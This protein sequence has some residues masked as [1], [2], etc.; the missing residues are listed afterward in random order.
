MV[1]ML[2]RKNVL[3]AK[4][5]TT[6]GV[7]PTPAAGDDA[8][9]ALNTEIKETREPIERN[10]NISTLSNKPSLLGGEFAEVTFSV[11]IKGS[12]SAGTAPRLGALLQA[13]SMSETV[14]SSTSVTY[15]PESSDQNSVTLW[16]YID[17]RLHKINGAVGTVKLNL[18]AGA[19]G[20][21]DFT[22]QGKYTTPTS[23]AI[24]SGT[25][26]TPNPQPCK[27]CT[28]TYDSKTTLIAKMLDVDLANTIAR[29]N[30]LS[31]S[32]GIAGFH[33]TAR[34]P[35]L[36]FDVE[37]QLETS[38]NFRSDQLSSQKEVSAVV[39][40]TA[41]NICTITV[42]K[43]NVTDIEY[44]D[45]EMTLL[46]KLTGECSIDSGDDELTIAFT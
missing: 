15:A 23:A 7:D 17:G 11:E 6:Y 4:L 13:C 36:T 28:F 9:L 29:R 12:G 45:E 3:L 34:K 21:L 44:G 10:I 42:P 24:V 25:Y 35:M 30:D 38:Y 8:I 27:S 41:G 40:A 37:A 1:V 5:E 20:M 46:E 26:D 19:L 16:V 31:A 18:T 14:V 22:F 32:T 43:Y 33:I 2:K 39:G